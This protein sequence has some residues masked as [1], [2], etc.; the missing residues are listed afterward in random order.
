MSEANC[1]TKPVEYRDIPGFPGYRVGDDG[2]VWSLWETIQTGVFPAT[3]TLGKK[4]KPVAIRLAK[5]GYPR[6][7]LWHNKRNNDFSVH[8]LVLISFVGP[9]PDGCEALHYD[10]I[11]TNNNLSNLRWG[12]PIENAADAM[13]N[14][15]ARTGL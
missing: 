15:R 8:K 1:T 14:G 4:L 2:S 7:S 10:D 5:N 3:R 9:C 12:T 6:V 13:R 11:R